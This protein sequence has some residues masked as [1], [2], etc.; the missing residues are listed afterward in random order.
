M[1]GNFVLGLFSFL[2]AAISVFVSLFLFVFVCMFICVCLLVFIADIQID[3]TLTDTRSHTYSHAKYI[4]SFIDFFL[5]FC[6][7]LSVYFACVLFFITHNHLS[8]FSHTRRHTLWKTQFN[9]VFT[10]CFSFEYLI[11]FSFTALTLPWFCIN[12]H[13]CAYISMSLYIF[14]LVYYPLCVFV[15]R[16]VYC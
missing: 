13:L 11:A 8:L 9:F 1:S 4:F 3:L 10:H 5:S 16:C 6:L 2:C 7:T 12:T 15:K 14:S